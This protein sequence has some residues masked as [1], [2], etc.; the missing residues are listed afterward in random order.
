MMRGLAKWERRKV[1]RGEQQVQ[2]VLQMEEEEEEEEQ[3]FPDAAVEPEVIESASLGE[4]TASPP[5]AVASTHAVATRRRS[6]RRVTSSEG[7]FPDAGMLEVIAGENLEEADEVS[8]TQSALLANSAVEMVSDDDVDGL[9]FTTDDGA[10]SE[11]DRLLLSSDLS[12]S[13]LDDMEYPLFSYPVAM[14]SIEEEFADTIVFPDAPDT[15]VHSDP[16]EV[17][18]PDAPAPALES[19]PA[20]TAFPDA[21]ESAVESLH[22]DTAFPD[23]ATPD[24]EPLEDTAFPD[25]PESAIA[26]PPTLAA[27][28]DTPELALL[29]PSAW[30]LADIACHDVAESADVAPQEL[31]ETAFPDAP[32]AQS[33]FPDAP[34]ATLYI[35]AEELAFLGAPDSAQESSVTEIAFPDEPASVPLAASEEAFPGAISSALDDEAVD[36]PASSVLLLGELGGPP[37]FPDGGPEGDESEGDEGMGTGTEFQAFQKA[38]QKAFQPE[39]ERAEEGGSCSSSAPAV[40][41]AVDADADSMPPPSIGWMPFC[42]EDTGTTD[43]GDDSQASMD[44]PP[45]TCSPPPSPP[46]PPPTPS[47]G[48]QCLI[49][50]GCHRGDFL[51]FFRSGETF[52]KAY[53]VGRKIGEG[54]FGK[55]FVAKHRLLGLSRAVK[56]LSKLHGKAESHKNE[57]AALL[58]LDHPHVVKLVEYYDEERYLYLVFELCQGPDLFD[59]VADEKKG[60]MSELDASMALRHILKGLQCCHSK[61]RGH[62]DVKPENFMYTTK[63]LSDLKMIDLGMSSGYDLHRR[64]NKIKGTSAYMAPEAWRGT[65]GPEADLWSVGIVLFVMLTGEPALPES[66]LVPGTM[67][68]EARVADLIRRRLKYASTT[69]KLSETAQ[70][71]LQLMLSHD[72]HG[73]PTVREALKHPFCNLSYENESRLHQRIHDLH[74]QEASTI[75]RNLPDEFRAITEEPMLKRVARLAMAHVGEV[76]PAQHLAFRMLDWHGY[77][78]LSVAV[79]EK[80]IQQRGVEIPADFDQLFETIDLLREG[81]ISYLCFLSVTLPPEARHNETLCHVTFRI[82]D[83]N[84]DGYIDISDLTAVFGNEQVC[85][86][87]LQEVSFENRLSFSDFLQMMREDVRMSEHPHCWCR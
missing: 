16:F 60:R 4:C 31:G 5:T 34:E 55:V 69:F 20:D 49:R 19:L 15:A 82:L 57:L 2:Q 77:G 71:L 73:R 78:E 83:R 43:F 79:L 62:F 23:A 29:S 74:F 37:A 51:M 17:A 32:V 9:N 27:F 12:L 64:R 36:A 81:Y 66:A 38:F 48:Q 28:S 1:D 33:A 61:Y 21:P 87:I 13:S 80:D 52:N 72:R 75:L 68:S 84:E 70:D 25:A 47:Q 59:R 11:E 85:L 10:A 14:D 54:G 26:Y 6:L 7:A 24:L 18:F 86:G 44:L 35:S 40:H 30:G 67:K 42:R 58:A 39:D 56:R 3:T 50:E 76:F 8:V 41:M 53:E 65:Y 22:A 63:E 45:P 46:S